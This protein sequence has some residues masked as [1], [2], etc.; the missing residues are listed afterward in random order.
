MS[1]AKKSFIFSATGTTAEDTLREWQLVEP[2]NGGPSSLI[3]AY[4]GL[5]R[6]QALEK[7]IECIKKVRTG[8]AGAVEL[9]VWDEN[10]NTEE[11]RYY[12]HLPTGGFR[13]LCKLLDEMQ[14]LSVLPYRITEFG[15]VR[16]LKSNGGQIEFREGGLRAPW[17]PW[18]GKEADFDYHYGDWNVCK[19]PDEA[20]MNYR[21]SVA[22][23][24]EP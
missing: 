7:A 1:R 4:P 16:V 11:I 6:G 21:K 14:S 18:T 10:D 12:P 22:K 8:P 9:H 2:I 17:K 3:E 19:D 23:R 15:L 13:D 24:V 20:V 5:N